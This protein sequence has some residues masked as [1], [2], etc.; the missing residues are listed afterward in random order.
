MLRNEADAEDAVQETII[1]YL[2]KAPAFESA[3]HEKAWLLTTAKNK[4]RDILR[5]RQRHPQA[6]IEYAQDLMYTP[7]DK[8]IMEALLSLPD[9]FKLVLVLYYVEEYGVEEIARII[10]R[11][12][13]A[14]KMRL[15]KGR[16]LLKSKYREE[17]M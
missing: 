12:P 17:Y 2:Q 4:C 10:N 13:S 3:E 15:R 9:K 1:K 11:T 6:A 16:E 14:V 5:F 7:S 8:G